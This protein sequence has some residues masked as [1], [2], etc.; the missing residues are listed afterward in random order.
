MRRGV[1]VIG[2]LALA[3]SS[4]GGDAAGGSGGSAG[5]AGGGAPSGGSAGAT[6]GGGAGG[7][8]SGSAGSSAGTAGSAGSA[9]TAGS[10]GSAGSAGTAGTGGSGGAPGAWQCPVGPFDTNPIPDDAEAA[11]VAGVPPDDNYEENGWHNIE[12]PVWIDGALYVSHITVVGAPPKA[13]IL[14]IQDGM[15]T[16]PFPEI[17]SNGLAVDGAGVLYATRHADGSIS[18]LDLLDPGNVTPVVT[19]YEGNRFNSPND[20]AIRSDGNVYFSD[21]DYQQPGDDPQGGETRVYRIAPGGSTATSIDDSLD[22][23]N[24]V[25]LSLDEMS[26]FVTYPNGLKKYALDAGG[27]P[28]AGTVVPGAP[29]GDGMGLDCAGNL[30]ITSGQG[31]V[32]LDPTGAEIDSISLPISNGT[33]NVA[34][35]GPERKTLYISH[36]GNDASLYSVEVNIPG[37]PY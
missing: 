28:D 34:F 8:S 15:V 2:S 17:G 7:G 21:P 19:T 29:G 23:P 4:N 20:L 36:L 13:R 25:T 27:T 22:Q 30:Y 9:G 33:T 16:V 3:C 32:V 5:N 11:Q 35:G 26:L 6:A 24:G 37:K 18:K 10:A 14:K 1:L 12:G 31:V